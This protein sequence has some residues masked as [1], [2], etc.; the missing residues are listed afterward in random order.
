MLPGR[1]FGFQPFGKPAEFV[2]LA[3][4]LPLTHPV[5]KIKGVVIRHGVAF[6]PH[7]HAAE[8]GGSELFFADRT[9]AD[10]KHGV[11]GMSQ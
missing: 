7:Q 8:P 1:N 5:G 4:F 10:R 2:I 9:A 6:P 3:Q 11:G